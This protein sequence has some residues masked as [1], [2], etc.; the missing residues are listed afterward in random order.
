MHIDEQDLLKFILQTLEVGK[1]FLSGNTARLCVNRREDI[2][3]IIGIFIKY[4]LQSTKYLNFLS[5]KKAFELYG[6]SSRKSP[7]LFEEI[8]KLKSN[9]NTLRTDFSEMETRKFSITP[10]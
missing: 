10:Y 9:M 4:P 6:S 5:F 7:E 8:S 3:N 2:A 1:V